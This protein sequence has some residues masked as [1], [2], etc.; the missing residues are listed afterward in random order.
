MAEQMVEIIHEMPVFETKVGCFDRSIDQVGQNPLP[1]GSKQ[2][3]DQREK[4]DLVRGLKQS[5][6]F[7][8]LD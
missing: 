1:F 2:I 6:W 5:F 7:Y 3:R 8:D 4:D